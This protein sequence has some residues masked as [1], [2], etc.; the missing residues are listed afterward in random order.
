MARL[1]EKKGL[2]CISRARS[3]SRLINSVGRKRVQGEQ[4][5][6]TDCLVPDL[7]SRLIWKKWPITV[8]SCR[9]AAVKERAD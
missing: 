7:E 6:R 5:L 8:L 2:V 9:L 4:S 1:F 3:P